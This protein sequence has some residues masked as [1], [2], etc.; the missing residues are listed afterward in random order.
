MMDDDRL[1]NIADR[2]IKSAEA[3]RDQL[4]KDRSDAVDYH[5]G[6]M[7]DLKALKGRSSMVSKDVRATIKKVMPSVLRTFT[8]GPTIW[9]FEPIGP[10]DEEAA[11]QATKYVNTVA[12]KESNAEEAIEDA[13]YDAM[14][15]RS[16]IIKVFQ[17]EKKT[18]HVS[19][20]DGL[21]EMAMTQLV[22]P[23][24]VQVIEQSQNVEVVET[25]QGPIEQLVYSVKIKRIETDSKPKVRAVPLERFLISEDSTDADEAGLVGEVQT[26]T[27]GDL[28]AMGYDKKQV[29]ALP[30]EEQDEDTLEA[31]R[32]DRTITD[33]VSR[34]PETEKSLQEIDYYEVYMRV[35]RDDDGLNELVRV[36]FGGGTKINNLLSVEDWDVQP[37]VDLIC[38]RQPHQREGASIADDT[39]DIQ[40]VKT[41]LLRATLDN[42]YWQNRPQPI[43][44]DGAIENEDA[45]LNPSFGKPIRVAAG[46][47]ARE[48]LTYTQVPL[49]AS[50]SFNMLSYFDEA[51]QDRTGISEASSGMAPDALQN[52][53]AKASAMIEAAGI[54]Q[55][56]R[57]VKT[58]SK[59]IARVGKRLLHLTVQHQDKPRT[60]RISNK[61][62]EYDP[63]SWNAGMDVTVN[64]GLGAGSKERDMQMLM[65]IMG[66][67]EK[68]IAAFGPDNPYVKPENL[69][70]TVAKLIEAAGF[71]SVEP[72]I[73]KPDDQEV[74]QR[75]EEAKNQPDPEQLKLQAQMQ[76]E[77]AKMQTNTAKEQAQ[78]DADLQVKQA[79]MAAQSR[80]QTEKLQSDATL[81]EQKLEFE[82]E[83]LATETALK[84]EEMNQKHDIELARL[85]DRKLRDEAADLSQVLNA[86]KSDEA[87]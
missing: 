7:P 9:D 32:D 79:E 52:M 80:S 31:T 81:A 70:N 51:I 10:E 49:V 48:A 33:K 84:Q 83:R 37:F 73:T 15:L 87:A 22:S 24:N 69:Y 13:C 30:I 78:M 64:T 18:V 55:T 19:Q 65:M 42:L 86:H 40:K 1:V 44:Q 60:V 25:E 85:E 26:L 36:C 77:E 54:G 5:N 41:V 2:L 61:W 34:D 3:Y 75:L 50:D 6:E 56:E 4:S 29:F 35:D 11:E 47:D 16:G 63:R 45:V 27:R 71:K 23:E 72:F 74:A 82:R 21:D 17:E 57:M 12:S 58:L 14:L 76:L 62:V 46:R 39:M 43:M 66:V 59:G 53:T 28:V 20:H 67:L 38:E 8:G 68:L